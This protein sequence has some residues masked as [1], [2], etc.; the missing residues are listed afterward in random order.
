MPVLTPRLSSYWLGLVT[1]VPANIA[2]A[3]IG[4]LKHDIPP[5][6][7]QLRALVPQRL[8]DVPRGG[9][10]RARRRACQRGRRALDRGRDDVPRL[11]PRLRVLRQEG[12]R[13]S[14]DTTRRPQRSGRSSRASAGAIGYFYLNFLWTLRELLDWLVGGP[15]FTR[16]RRD[17][18]ELR[19][20]DTIDYWTVS[21]WSPT[22]A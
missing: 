22:G 2:R 10:G 12:R 4:G 5:D 1:A 8:L 11:P 21:V 7:A 15:G 9:R 3:L 16:G 19:L 14:A 17:P 20:G 13:D 18:A 6:D